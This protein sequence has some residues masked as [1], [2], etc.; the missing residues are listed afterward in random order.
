MVFFNY[1]IFAFFSLP[2]RWN[3]SRRSQEG[4]YLE[5]QGFLLELWV[6]LVGK[7]LTLLEAS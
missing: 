2:W 5:S 6:K 1:E 7:T 3:T 4:A